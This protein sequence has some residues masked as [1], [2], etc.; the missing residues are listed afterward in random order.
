MSI[1]EI[2]AE[3]RS[4]M[5]KGA[6]RRLRRDGKVPAIV[7]GGDEK[8]QSIALL[9]SEVL[10]RLDHEAFYSHILTVNVDGKAH[11]AV[12]RD[13]QRHPAKPTVMHMDFQRINENEAIRVRVPLHFVGENVAPGVKAGGMVSHEMIEVE[14][15]VLPRHLPE[16]I[17]VDVSGLAL[18]EALKLSDLPLP[19][20][21]SVVEL[22]RGEDHDLPV[23]SVHTRRGAA[24]AVEGEEGE[25][26]EGG[27]EV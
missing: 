14:L 3:S 17:E 6:S 18:G 21:G 20:S 2:E 10:K 16:Y 23:V 8:P 12:L 9:H 7:Y 5:G 11:K 26:G 22:S 13:I 25:A 24:E 27:A 4:D 15:E 1:F 19:E